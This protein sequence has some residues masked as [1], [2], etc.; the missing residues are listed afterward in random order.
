[1]LDDFLNWLR[2]LAEGDWDEPM[3][4]KYPMAEPTK[5]PKILAQYQEILD[6]EDG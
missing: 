1:M 6:R 5:D 3:E 2:D 4:F